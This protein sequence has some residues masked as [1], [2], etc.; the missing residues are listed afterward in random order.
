M[1]HSN[2]YADNKE[3]NDDE[4]SDDNRKENEESNV[5]SSRGDSPFNGNDE[6]VQI[7]EETKLLD[8]EKES[9]TAEESTE[10]CPQDCEEETRLLDTEE[11][12]KQQE[13]E[14]KLSL[15]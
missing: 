6:S 9:N 2:G 14:Q 3:D 12:K 4:K 5:I 7:D 1:N 15:E 13:D 10:L 11:V 8:V